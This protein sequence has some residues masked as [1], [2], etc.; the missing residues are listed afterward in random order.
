MRVNSANYFA[1]NLNYFCCYVRT[2]H[3]LHEKLVYLGGS[4][5]FAI[6]K[7]I[8]TQQIVLFFCAS[9]LEIRDDFSLLSIRYWFSVEMKGKVIYGDVTI[10]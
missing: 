5:Q 3:S 10:A 2:N 4:H 1:R 9:S 7:V 6:L 8:I